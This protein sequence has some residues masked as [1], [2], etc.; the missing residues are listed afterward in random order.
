MGM[1][2][3]QQANLAAEIARNSTGVKRVVKIFEYLEQ[4]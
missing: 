3:R 1:V 4:N 2:T